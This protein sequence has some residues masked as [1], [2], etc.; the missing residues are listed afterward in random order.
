MLDHVSLGVR[1]LARST[2]FY[3]RVLGTLGYRLHRQLATEVAYGPAD[4]WVFFLYPAEAAQ[5]IVGARMHIAFRAADRNGVHTFYRTA[6]A[7]GASAVPDREPAERPQFGADYFGAVLND[8]DGHTL[9]VLT[10]SP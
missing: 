4:A 5:P 3:E 7:A 1:D 2:D 8:P 9:E 10:R 6:L